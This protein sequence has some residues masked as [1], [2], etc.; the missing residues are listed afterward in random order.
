M[1]AI[2]KRKID[3]V[4]PALPRHVNR[5]AF[6]KASRSLPH[7][8]QDEISPQLHFQVLPHQ[9]A[10]MPR[11]P[12]RRIVVGMLSILLLTASAWR[13]AAQ[14][15][16]PDCCFPSELVQWLP[17]AANPLFTASGPGHWDVMI[18]ERGWIMRE[19]NLYHLWFTGYDGT[20]EGIKLLG[21]AT[22]PDGIRWNTWPHNPIYRDHWVEDMMVIKHGDTYYMFAE[23]AD[24]NHAVMLTSTDR[25]H[26]T[27]HGPLEV[28]Q[29]DGQRPVEKPCGTPTIWIENQTWYLFYERGD[30]G[31]WLARSIDPRSNVWTNVRDEP[32]LVP[33][34]A[35][36]DKE[37]IALN[38][39]IRHKGVYYAFYHG[40]GDREPP[41]KW[42]TNIARSSDLLHWHKFAG[43]PLLNDK[44]SGIV[45]HDGCQYRLYT[46]HQQVELFFPCRD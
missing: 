19:N 29:R 5:A 15:Y 30:R 4:F 36:Y 25:A 16:T 23:G 43:N 28:R 46:M 12:R 37:L 42:N 41:R 35:Q 33:G 7:P 24:Q 34:P 2:G 27:W 6:R 17:S 3:S 31:V 1:V 22:S 14:N 45:V 20:R 26:W 38:Q 18:R 44:S 32:V 11:L 21:Y 13:A 40:S 10:N 8:D 39:V 9:P